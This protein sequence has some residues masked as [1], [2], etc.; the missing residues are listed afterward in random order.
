MDYIKR[1]VTYAYK[2]FERRKDWPLVDVTSK[3]IE[4]TAAEVVSLIG[5]LKGDLD[6]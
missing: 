4:E 3:P 5:K 6:Q 2:V 1:E